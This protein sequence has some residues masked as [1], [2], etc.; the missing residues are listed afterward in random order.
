MGTDRVE[1]TV[2]YVDLGTLP[3]VFPQIKD[4]LE[5]ALEY[6]PEYTMED[7]LQGV[8]EGA[9]Q[10]FIVHQGDRIVGT[11]V[12]VL[13][14]HP[15]RSYVQI[16]LLGGERAKEWAQVLREKLKVWANELGYDGLSIFARRG[17]A[18]IFPDLKYERVIMIDLI[19][20]SDVGKE[21]G[22]EAESSGA[23]DSERG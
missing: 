12:T 5:G 23:S 17:W 9:S 11:C 1:Y 22:N 19:G 15:R 8:L 21:G 10:L 16:H 14:K 18:K 3:Q 2:S 13:E 4:Y 6:A 7:V 20:D